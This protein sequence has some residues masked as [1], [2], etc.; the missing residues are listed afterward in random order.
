MTRRASSSDPRV[1]HPLW[2]VRNDQ[3]EHQGTGASLT[4]AHAPHTGNTRQTA[5]CTTT[6]PS[7]PRR[8]SRT[9]VDGVA[10][11]FNQSTPRAAPGARQNQTN[12]RRSRLRAAHRRA[13]RKKSRDR[14]PHQ[15]QVTAGTGAPRPTPPRAAAARK[16]PRWLPG[17]QRPM[18]LPPPPTA[19]AA[20]TNR[21][22]DARRPTHGT[23]PHHQPPAAGH[24]PNR[25]ASG[26]TSPP[27]GARPTATP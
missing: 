15:D 26:G 20:P 24:A 12:P 19:A 6:P 23:K 22:V 5:A 1:C 8:P 3:L 13:R 14:R 2:S 16:R 21:G 17:T 27:T 7:A 25:R 9:A 11:F 4:V 10:V 18:P